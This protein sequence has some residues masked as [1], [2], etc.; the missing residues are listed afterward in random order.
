[1]FED[2]IRDAKYGARSLARYPGFATVA[3]LTLALGIGANTVIFSAFNAVML[4]PLPYTDP[5][6]VVTVWDSYPQ[7]GAAKFGVTYANLTDLKERNHVFE[8][9]ALYVAASNTTFN[10][11]GSAGP[12]RIQGTRAT[13][14]FFRALKVGPLLGR[15]ITAEDE[16]QGSNH[17]VVLGYTLWRREFGSDPQIVDRPLKLNDEDY[18]VIGVMPQGFEFPSGPEMP[19]GQQFASATE[20]WV[21]LTVPADSPVRNDRV[22]HAYRALARLKPGVTIEQARA[23]TTTLVQQLVAEHPQENQGLGVSVITLKENQVGTFRPALLS[24]LIAVG[25]VLLI[26][27]ANIAN[28]LLSRAAVRRKEFAVRAALGASRRRILQQLLTESLL[29][30]AIGGALGLLL[31]VVATRFLIAFVPANIPRVSEVSIDL[32]VLAF[33]ASI[34]LVTGVLF[35]IVPALHASRFN[36]YE[37][38]KSEGR[39]VAGAA[40]QNRLRSL[41]VIS[42]V[43]LVFVLLIAGGLMLKSFRRLLDVAAGFDPERVLTARITLPPIPYPGQKKAMF[44]HQLIERLEQTPGIEEAA[45]IRDLPLSGTDPRYG[46]TVEGRPDAQQNGGYTIRYRIISPDYF[47]VMGIQLKRGR[48]FTDH[49]DQNAPSVAIINESA[50]NQIFPGEDPLGKVLLTG[51]AYAPDH[52]QVVGVIGDVKFGGL[53]SQPDAEFYIPYAKLPEPVIQPIIGSMAVVI[54]GTGDSSSLTGQLRQQVA[55]IDKNVPLSSVRTMNDLLANSLA[56]RKFNLLLLIVFGAVSLT[57]AAV[58][59]YGV[60]S[61]W[62]AQRIREIGIRMALGAQA[63]DIFKLVVFQAMSVVSIGL[64]IGV[65]A[66]IA[67][68]RILS[69][70]LSSLLFGVRATDPATF[71]VMVLLLGATAFAAC[72][73]PAR[74]AVKVEPTT[75][76]RAE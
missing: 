56:P 69:S 12:E 43:V 38:V 5:E 27:C 74:R 18:R 42:E 30:S 2:L 70:T 65:V 20:L 15:A 9:L 14:D 31:S 23:E 16:Q 4:R 71:V 68:T 17:V 40:S 8:P 47:K 59:I 55:A 60:L 52:C 3:I 48:S 62:V 36:L 72:Y 26:A 51:G 75:A 57:L 63:F 19:A 66:A 37:G 28:L 50:A 11:T 49:D 7:V 25:F 54:R 33:T 21:P 46:V 58:G 13:G 76:L 73:F 32:R 45:V 22:T 24:L 41:L 44:Y 1:M 61:Y 6:R 53:D 64:G 10:L 29:L 34:S 35:G 67:L 39:G